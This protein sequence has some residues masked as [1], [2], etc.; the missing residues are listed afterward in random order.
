MWKNQT[1]PNQTRNC[2]NLDNVLIYVTLE[3]ALCSQHLVSVFIY[4][5][6]N[7]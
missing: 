2:D 3:I 5:N 4:K 7:G 6:Q 1:K